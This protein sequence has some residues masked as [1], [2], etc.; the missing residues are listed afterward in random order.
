M[1]KI[2]DVIAKNNIEIDKLKSKNKSFQ[3]KIVEN[4]IRIDELENISKQLQKER[5]EEWFKKNP[6][7][8]FYKKIRKINCNGAIQEDYINIT[9]E[10][11]EKYNWNLKKL[12]KDDCYLQANRIELCKYVDSMNFDYAQYNTTY[13]IYAYSF[14]P[15]SISCET[16]ECEWSPITEDEYLEAK[17]VAI[18]FIKNN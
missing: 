3:S 16:N 12:I 5:L 1:E 6:L 17:K 18:D 11:A 14:K 13:H 4:K 8:K 10:N 7:K 15:T 2:S 9:D